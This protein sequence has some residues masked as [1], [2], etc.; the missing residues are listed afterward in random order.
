[1]SW[2]DFQKVLPQTASIGRGGVLEIGGCNTAE[3]AKEFGTPLFVMD[4]A[5]LR[6]RIG[7][8]K[9]A[10]GPQNVYYA[11]KAFLTKSFAP[12]AA[13]EGICLDCVAG[14]EVY[15]ALA[16]GFPASRIGVHGNNKSRSEIV[17]ALEAGVGRIVVD[18]FPELELLREVTAEIG[19]VA[20]VLLRIT[21]GV[22]V[23]T[24]SYLSTGVED[25]KFGFT[26]GDV[27]M[28]AVEAAARIES[29]ELAGLHSHI[30]SQS[31]ELEP[32]AEAARKM[33]GFLA[34]AR[35]TTALELPELDLGG[36]LGI[37][38]L[39]S[40]EPSSIEDLAK[41]LHD[42]VGAEAERLG[43]PI[44][45]VKVEP[46]R[47]IAGPSM[48][49]LYT[50]GTI[51]DVAGKRYVAVDGGMSD[52]IRVPL[53]QAKY[54]YL[55]ASR[56][57]AIHDRPATIAGKLCETGDLIGFDIALP[58]VEAGEL[59]ACAATGAYGYSMASN[60]NKQPRPAVIAAFGGETRLL[61]R[62]ESYEDLV[63]LEG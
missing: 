56:P 32:F 61:A 55:S 53:Y 22:D 39:P 31:F 28:R 49:T 46:G 15:T 58:E 23:H 26:I 17:E 51:K 59:L 41:V 52:N 57:E 50:A 40:D 11:T 20:R 54:T 18:S 42:A 35:R 8:Y 38:Y 33:V 43:T 27:A 36:G 19:T 5:E 24:H 62:R 25:S 30:G 29:V 1:M 4:L 45:T 34:E 6:D 7:R 16:G 21:P 13:E 9:D 44:P 63:R 37:A 60:Y 47:S 48:V 3:L 14:G 2:E 10:F 12:I